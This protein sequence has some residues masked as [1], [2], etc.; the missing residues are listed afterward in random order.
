MVYRL[1]CRKLLNGSA[2]FQQRGQLRRITDRA[3]VPE[4]VLPSARCSIC[5]VRAHEESAFGALWRDTGQAEP[6]KRVNCVAGVGRHRQN[7]SRDRYDKYKPRASSWWATFHEMAPT[8]IHAST[9]GDGRKRTAQVDQSCCH[10]QL[11]CE[12][13]KMPRN[14]TGR[15]TIGQRLIQVRPLGAT[16][17]IR[18]RS[19]V[20]ASRAGT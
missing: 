17:G 7:G 15:T 19:A 5:A 1:I 8:V 3:C 11:S 13:P 9:G 2:G 4:T 20:I 12:Q 10:R 14:L 16:G 6:L 18:H